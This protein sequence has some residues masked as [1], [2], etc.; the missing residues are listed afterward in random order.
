MYNYVQDVQLLIITFPLFQDLKITDATL[1]SFHT[2]G[3]T[4]VFA[5]CCMSGTL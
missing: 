4:S 1:V 2:I 3:V 5:N